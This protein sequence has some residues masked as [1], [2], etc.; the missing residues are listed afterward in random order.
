V[1]A[2]GVRFG[3][4][5]ADAGYGLSAP[6]R[7]GLSAR[8][9]VWS[10]GVPRTQKV[11][12]TG[13]G[14]LFPRANKGKPRQ[15][16]VPSEDARAGADVLD[17]CRWRRI[18]WRQGSKGALTARFAA[19]RVGCRR[20]AQPASRPFARRG[21][22]ADRRMAQQRR[23]EILSEQSAARHVA[24]PPRRQHQSAVGLRAGPS[25]A[26][27]RTRPRGFRGTIV[28][29]AA[30][31]CAHELHRLCLPS[32][33]AAPCRSAGKK[34]TSPRQLLRSRRFLKSAALSSLD[35]SLRHN[36]QADVRIAGND[37]RANQMKCQS[38]ARPRSPKVESP[39]A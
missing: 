3:C 14:L 19:L 38:S 8:D 22:L 30:S 10:V 35:C 33:P 13:V 20:A 31:A 12:T 18:I 15:H 7:Q 16:A 34:R 23:A 24:A 4:V 21:G 9:L 32:A 27:A 26:Q 28:D 39:E 5:L 17:N 37:C 11:F 25:A 2:A 29:R 36:G 6:F 1:R